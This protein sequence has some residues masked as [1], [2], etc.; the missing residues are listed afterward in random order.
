MSQNITTELNRT[1]SC[2]SDALGGNPNA[3]VTIDIDSARQINVNGISWDY[4]FNDPQDVAKFVFGRAFGCLDPIFDENNVGAFGSI[5][6]GSPDGVGEVFFVQTNTKEVGGFVR[7]EQPLVIRGDH[8]VVFVATRP[9]LTGVAALVFAT[10]LTV[11]GEIT[12]I[13]EAG[14]YQGFRMR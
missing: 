8:R 1:V 13:Q 11:Y 2:R 7:F 14:L 6:T 10:S 5:Y 9:V 3:L 4:Q 12:P